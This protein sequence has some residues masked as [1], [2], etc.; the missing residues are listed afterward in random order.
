MHATTMSA[1]AVAALAAASSAQ[2][3]VGLSYNSPPTASSR[4]AL[5]AAAGEVM[6]R[7]DSS[8]LA[9]WG[10]G[11][12]GY[13]TIQSLYFVVQDNLGPSTASTFAI[14]LYPE[15][16]S[17][18]NTPDLNAGVVFA[19]GVQGPTGFGV[20]VATSKVVT[21]ASPVSVPIQGDGDVFV[22]FVLP[23]TSSTSSLGIQVVLGYQPSAAFSVFDQPN[24]SQGTG[25]PTTAS[26]ATSHAC[27]RVGNATAVTYNLRRHHVLDIGHA[28]AG[29]RAL[30]ITN[31]SNYAAS[32][33][34]A[35]SGYGPAPGTGNLLSGSF[36]DGSSAIAGRVD[37]LAMQFQKTGIG[38]GAPVVFMI[39][40]ADDFGSEVALSSVLTGSGVVCLSATAQYLGASLTVADEAWLVLPI[41]AAVRP[42]L[43]G[44]PV[45]QQAAGFDL[46][47]GLWHATPCSGQV[48]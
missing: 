29:G 43:L 4:G 21:P 44:L 24:A 13:R 33:N 6:T 48:L 16:A 45:K 30:G 31:Q 34:P 23:A 5:G 38:S 27:T 1:L 9:G 15:S 39:D 36:P 25:V 19:T 17:T 22:S 3:F 42:L 8:E 26:A 41:P 32:N 37:D 7:I 10:I 20:S 40:F 18:P 47:T 2:D 14:K 12:T 46:T 35:P 28:G 11:T